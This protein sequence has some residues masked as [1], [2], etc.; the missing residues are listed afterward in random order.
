MAKAERA[1]IAAAIL[2]MA[3]TAHAGPAVHAS[4]QPTTPAQPVP[5]VATY[6]IAWH[7][8]TA[9]SSTLELRQTAPQVYLYTST[10]KAYGVFRLAFPHPLR[11]SSRFRI[12]A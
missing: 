4:S 12:A 3:A 1:V 7:G 5:F 8:M 2:A 9:G 6:T 10:D 11:Q